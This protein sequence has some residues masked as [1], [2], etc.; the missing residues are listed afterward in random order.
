M[1]LIIP[2][3]YIYSRVI[4]MTYSNLLVTLGKQ[5]SKEILHKVYPIK[6]EIEY[7]RIK[8]VPSNLSVVTC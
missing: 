2:N 5:K 8:G 6:D 1:S 4:N 3:N 7:T